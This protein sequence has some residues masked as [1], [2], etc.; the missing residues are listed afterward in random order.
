MY[1]VAN[2]QITFFDFNQS[3]GMQLDGKNEWIVLA[4]SIDWDRWELEYAKMFKSPKGCTHVG[5]HRNHALTMLGSTALTLLGLARPLPTLPLAT[6]AT[7][8]AL[9]STQ[10]VSCHLAGLG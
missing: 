10:C 6:A 1:K 7:A 9:I 5:R 4:D 8:T 3:C 2:H